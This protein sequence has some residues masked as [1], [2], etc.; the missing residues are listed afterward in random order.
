[1]TL[2]DV[3]TVVS[4]VASIASLALA[5][6]TIYL[7]RATDRATR[8]LFDRTQDMMNRQHDRTKDVLAEIDKRAAVID[9]VV[10]DAQQKMLETLT[11]VFQGVVLPQK[12][13]FGEQMT[14]MLMQSL[15]EDPT[16]AGKV[17]DELAPLIEL[18]QKMQNQNKPS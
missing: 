14:A 16:K 4:L 8:A 3:L 15:F 12:P 7:A 13:A 11:T 1:M 17:F 18:G 5:L 6:F 2:M 10:T 9:K